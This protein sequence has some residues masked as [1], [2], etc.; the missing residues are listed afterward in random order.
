VRALPQAIEY[1]RRLNAIH[2]LEIGWY[3][4]VLWTMMAWRAGP[5]VRDRVPH[6]A[7]QIAILLAIPWSAGL[8]FALYR[9][10]L[11]L[12]YGLSIERW[13]QWFLDLA[14]STA[15]AGV[16]T[17]LLMFAIFEMA[18]RWPRRWWMLAWMLSVLVML[19]GAY[20]E[21]LLVDPLFFRF[22]PLARSSPT[23]AEAL[24]D[25][26]NHAGYTIPSDR[27]FEMDAGSKT[28]AVNAYMTGFGSSRRIVIWDTALNALTIPQTQ[29]VFAHELGHYALGH[30]PLG[31][32]LAALGLLAGFALL[33]RLLGA[34]D[35]ANL[36]RLLAMALIAAFL[37]EPVVNGVSR[38]IEHQADVYELDTMSCLIPDAGK[39]SAEVDRILSRID[40]DDPDPSAFI[41]FW[42]CDHPP[43]NERIR[44]AEQ[45]APA[46]CGN[47]E[48]GFR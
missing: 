7:A 45:Y 28:R 30:I 12:E 23:L 25:V 18:H 14:K 41:R 47:R 9:H 46:P 19:A 44:F 24:Q 22:E 31:I 37:A 5:K 17:V 32:G 48:T 43:T 20:A 38:A 8:P 2:F 11:S 34:P 36:P 13:S 1:H 21:P 10:S 6:Q 27:I 3:A 4:A 35:T 40:L 16:L 42:L 29:T 15:I 33:R 26:A 39:N